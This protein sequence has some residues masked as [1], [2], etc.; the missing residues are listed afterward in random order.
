MRQSIAQPTQVDDKS[1]CIS[2][3]ILTSHPELHRKS[4]VLKYTMSDH[5]L[6]YTYIEF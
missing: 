2:D 5:F 3:A 1:S 4:A 6:I